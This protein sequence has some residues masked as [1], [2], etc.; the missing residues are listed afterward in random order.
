M[1]DAAESK[2]PRIGLICLESL[3]VLGLKALLRDGQEFRVDV[4]EETRA[5]DLADLDVVVIDTHATEHLQALIEAFR[6]MRPQVR[7]LVLGSETDHAYTE[8]VIGAGA[9]G[10]LC[11]AS[12][13]ADLRRAVAVVRDGS[14]WAPRKVLARLLERAR[15]GEA[16]TRDARPALTRREVQVL[17]LLVLGHPNRD[18]AAALGVDEGTVKSHLGRL[19][20]KAGVKNRT[21]LMLRSVE[22]GWTS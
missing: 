10:Y 19:M 9:Q 11:H 17:R 18:I 13:E 1:A 7:L 3:R 12:S 2:L 16:S 15:A 22:G 4:L 5:A 8:S 6:R 21:A 14:M 20:R